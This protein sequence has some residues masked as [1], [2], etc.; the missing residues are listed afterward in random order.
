L[1]DKINKQQATSNKQQATSNKQATMEEHDD[2]AAEA[3]R[4]QAEARR[5]RILEKADKRMGVVSGEQAL[6]EE[7][8]KASA[9][10][11]ARIRAAR[12]R[13][14]GKKSADAAAV[15]SKEVAAG[16][17]SDETASVPKEEPLVDNVAEEET[18]KQLD[19]SKGAKSAAGPSG[20]SSEEPK[21]KYVGVARMRRNMIKKKKQ[22]DSSDPVAG[23]PAA[24]VTE[25]SVEPTEM[26]LDP[27]RVPRFPIYMHILTIL[28]LFF[29]G[30]DV[31]FQQYHQLLEV[32]SS[33]AFSQHG[34]PLIHRALGSPSSVDASKVTLLESSEA[35]NLGADQTQ[36]LDEFQDKETQDT[37]PNIDP[38][39]GVDLD[40]LTKGSG[41]MN[42]LAR[43]AVATHRSIIWLVYFL[44]LG[45]LQSLLSVPQALLRSPPA[46]C[47]TALALRHLV[48]KGILGA[49]I[50]ESSAGDE[51]GNAIDVLAMAKNFVTTSLNNNFPTAVVLYEAF[52]HLR[53]DMYIL[54]CGVFSG[55]IYVHLASTAQPINDVRM[56]PND[57]E[58]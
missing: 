57:G 29:A 30:M 25:S 16:A 39:F 40:E 32:E 44:P 41:V 36:V 53:S 58:L 2:A 17:P 8:K 31:S 1:D 19:E 6:P 45:I 14:Y 42:K 22:E 51:K 55:L 15:G 18:E 56:Q 34:I 23:S 35:E 48:G 46:L 50:P 28:L 49:G 4:A 12:Q 27:L 7:D 5:K 38:L 21:K 43:G 37:I 47:L 9:S 11:A 26:L 54:L 52:T 13:R 10:K 3:A 20:S 33:F 24:P